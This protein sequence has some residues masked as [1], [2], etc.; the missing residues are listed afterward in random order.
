MATATTPYNPNVPELLVSGELE[1]PNIR[2]VFL[3]EFADGAPIR[4]V[5]MDPASAAPVEAEGDEAEGDGSG[6]ALPE[7][8]AA[9]SPADLLEQESFPTKPVMTAS[10]LRIHRVIAPDHSVVTQYDAGA[11]RTPLDF[12]DVGGAVL[13]STRPGDPYTW[14]LMGLGKPSPDGTIVPVTGVRAADAA[15]SAALDEM[16]PGWLEACRKFDAERAEQL[17]AEAIAEASLPTLPPPG[18]AQ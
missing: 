17:A 18:P 15:E 11:D 12:L 7:I 5:L 6:A 14:Q 9:A 3:A 1:V 10:G 8:D 2:A 4:E 16:Y 13:A